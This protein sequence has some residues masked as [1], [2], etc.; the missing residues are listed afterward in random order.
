MER[1]IWRGNVWGIVESLSSVMGWGDC[2]V[3]RDESG[4]F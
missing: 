3:N 1:E 2:G 4:R